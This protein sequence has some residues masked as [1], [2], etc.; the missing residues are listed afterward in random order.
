MRIKNIYIKKKESGGR[1]R[2]KDSLLTS[3]LTNGH[4]TPNGNL[5]IHS[6]CTRTVPM[7]STAPIINM[8][9]RIVIGPALC[10]MSN[11]CC[12][13]F[14]WAHRTFFPA[15]TVTRPELPLLSNYH[16]CGVTVW[17]IHPPILSYSSGARGTTKCLSDILN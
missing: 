15:F 7:T 10:R 16:S 13:V 1:E 17:S 3:K 12:A 14:T 2:W 5:M 8:L 9:T 6:I 11:T 4:P